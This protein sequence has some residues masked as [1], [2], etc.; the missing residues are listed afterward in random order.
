MRTSQTR[1][2]RT[3]ALLA[4]AGATS[5]LRAQQ[6]APDLILSNGKIITVDERFTHCAGGGY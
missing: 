3:L 5:L 4:M 1:A 6:P 2:F